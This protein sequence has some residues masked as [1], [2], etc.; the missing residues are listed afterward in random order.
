MKKI[1]LIA[2]IPSHLKIILD[3]A[4]FL[5]ASQKF[6]PVIIFQS[7]ELYRFANKTK[8]SLDYKHYIFVSSKI[9]KNFEVKKEFFLFK[10]F[11]SFKKNW[12]LIKKTLIN[13]LLGQFPIIFKIYHSFVSNLLLLL[14]LLKL[15]LIPSYLPKELMN[16]LKKNTIKEILINVF[17]DEWNN[18]KKLSIL[19]GINRQKKFSQF[20][21]H[22]LKQDLP[23]LIIIPEDNLFYEGHIINYH[24]KQQK[25][26]T[27]I[28][29]FTIINILEWAEAFYHEQTFQ[30]NFGINRLTQ[31]LFPNWVLEYKNKKLILPPLYIL[32]A[33]FFKTCPETPWLVNSGASD[34]IAVENQFMYNYYCNSGISP[35]KL[36]ITGTL[37]DDKIFKIQSSLAESKLNLERSLGIK[38]KKKIV[39]VA[40]PPN[41][42][43]LKLRPSM[44]FREYREL[45]NWMLGSIAQHI[46]SETTV[47]VNLHPRIQ[48]NEVLP[49]IE[50]YQ[51]TLAPQSVEELI[52]LADLYIAVVSA[53]IRTAL[54]CGVPVINY[55]SYHYDYIDFKDLN[56][57]LEVKTKQEYEHSLNEV[58]KFTE[59][60]QS[61]KLEQEKLAHQM[62]KIDGHATA[63]ILQLVEHAIYSQKP[64]LEHA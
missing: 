1:L 45:I 37:N 41:Q 57:V 31:K 26:K 48:E 14:F 55:D 9:S 58:L 33:E 13:H 63:R 40:L 39:L 25:I 59:R 49:F 50:K 22:I 62:F 60:Y 46:D 17:A 27:L 61:L 16:F 15:A 42:F 23:S 5:K 30:I 34:Y 4:A 29:P 2:T 38:L 36:F 6:E 64:Q 32:G 11:C 20:L 12:F 35:Q 51:M 18:K 43:S 52:P 44:E 10:K 3:T 56:G 21:H 53:T 28:V 47:L 19:P 7:E 24:A 8:A 54:S